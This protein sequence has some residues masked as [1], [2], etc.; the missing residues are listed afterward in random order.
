MNYSTSQH[1]AGARHLRVGDWVQV[2]SAAEILATLDERQALDGMPFMP[3]MLQYCG[4]TF[5]VFRVAH[6]TCDT[7]NEYSIRSISSAVHLEGLRC[8]GQA[9]EGCDAGCLLFWKEAW[10]QRTAPPSSPEA[11]ERPIDHA[12]YAILLNGTHSSN[13]EGVQKRYRCQATDLYAFARPVRRRDRW[14]PLFYVKDLTSGNVS[15]RRFVAYGLLAIVNA[16]TNRWFTRRYPVV[17]GRACSR[18]PIATA[19]LEPGDLVHVKSKRE[20]VQT[21]DVNQRNRG[22]FFDVEMVPYCERGPYRILR[23][24]ERI[25]DEKTG[26][27]IKLPNACH[28]LDGVSC[29]GHLSMNRMFCPRNVYPFWRETWLEKAADVAPPTDGASTGVTS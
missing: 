16:F 22:L 6:K 21:L 24:V 11:V 9:H 10:L 17:R 5:R 7:I 20:I 8:D 25:V 2:R 29:S 14:N 19:N 3:E 18:T 28:V 26:A 12:H 23:R 4:R 13:D 15:L 1:K 27:L